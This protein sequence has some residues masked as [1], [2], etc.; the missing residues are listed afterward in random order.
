MIKYQK[1]HL[2]CAMDFHI[3]NIKKLIVTV[4]FVTIMKSSL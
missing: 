2:F 1:K 4:V 3:C